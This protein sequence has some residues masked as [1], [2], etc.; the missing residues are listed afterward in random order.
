MGMNAGNFA[1]SSRRRCLVQDQ[2]R[3]AD[4][5]EKHQRVREFLASVGADALVLQDSANIAWFTAGA[6]L[7]RSTADSC[8]TSV[9]ITEMLDCLPQTP[10]IRLSFLSVKLLALDFS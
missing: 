9:F 1:D 3:V 6:D 4:V 2:R 8:Q 5:E 7:A 10:L